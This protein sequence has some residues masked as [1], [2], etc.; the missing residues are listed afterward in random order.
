MKTQRRSFKE[1][2]ELKRLDEELPLLEIQKLSLEDALSK[3]AGDLIKLSK[4]LAIA[5][6]KLQQAEDRWLELSELDP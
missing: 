4:E 2:K 1:S 6:Q 5:I 3:G